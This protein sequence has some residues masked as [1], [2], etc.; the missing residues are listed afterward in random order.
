MKICNAGHKIEFWC[1]RFK[2]FKQVECVSIFD[3]NCL[4]IK[5]KGIA[6]VIHATKDE[7]DDFLCKFRSNPHEVVSLFLRKHGI[8]LYYQDTLVGFFDIQAFS[9]YLDRTSMEEAIRSVSKLFSETR[10]VASTDFMDVKLDHWILSDSIILVIDTCR[11][12]LFT[13][14]IE[15]FMVTCSNFMETAIKQGFPLRGAI[16][17]GDF[18][19]DGEILISTGLVDA[20][21]YEKEQDWLGAVLTPNAI[22]LVEKAKEHELKKT[23]KTEIDFHS[24]KFR[25]SI[26]FGKI[27]WKMNS[28]PLAKPYESFYINPFDFDEKDWAAKY[29]PKHFN[30]QKKID[31]SHCLYAEA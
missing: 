10:S 16:G 26:R 4:N 19:K 30:C 6:K 1:E 21:S 28:S 23:G 29:L 8:L 15:F 22:K 27:P 20:A 25:P 12:P 9:N 3:G 24:E 31:N 11:H 5:I 14:S 13:G 17:G 7:L 18:Y 2:E